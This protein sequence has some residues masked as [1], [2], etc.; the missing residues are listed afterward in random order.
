VWRGQRPDG[1]PNIEVPMGE[2]QGPAQFF[3]QLIQRVA[4]AANDNEYMLVPG[5]T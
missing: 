2:M 4:T 5:T 3:S 1:V